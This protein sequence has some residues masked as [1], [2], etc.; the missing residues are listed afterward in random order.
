MGPTHTGPVAEP[1][2]ESTETAIHFG[3]SG[4]AIHV[5]ERSANS[6]RKASSPRPDA[7]E[8]HTGAFQKLLEGTG[9]SRK[10]DPYS[11]IT[12]PTPTIV[13]GGRQCASRSTITPNKT[14]S[15]DLYY[16]C[17][18]RRVG[19]SL[20]QT[21][22]KKNLVHSRKQ[23]ANKLSGT[24]NSLSSLKRVSRQ[25]FSCSNQQHHSIVIHKQGRRHEVRDKLS[26]L[27]QIIQAE[28]SLLPEVFQM[29]CS[30]WHQPQIDLFATRF[31]KLPLF[32]SPEYQTPWPKLYT[33]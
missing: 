28:W 33:P 27:A 3:L 12:A 4:L 16:R 22:C 23:A 29:I 15:A 17:I 24:Q 30:R 1:S 8:T 18:E 13:A 32:L 31:N 21:H 7:Y 20:K 25:D 9:I 6:H 26:R 5:L 14:C 11:Q 10:S 2:R 19:R